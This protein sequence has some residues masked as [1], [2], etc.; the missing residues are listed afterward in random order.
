M[1]LLKREI[2]PI[3]P[4]AWSEI[5]QEARRVLNVK[6]AGRRIVDIDGP[7]GWELGAVNTGL[8]DLFDAHADSGVA[9]GLRKVQPLVEL[10]VPFE[11]N[12]LEL[13]SI[14]RGSETP[15]LDPVAQAAEKIALAEDN[16]IFNGYPEAGI[17]GILQAS[18]HAD[19]PFGKSPEEHMSAVVKARQ[20]L[21]EAGVG[22]PFALLLGPR[23][24]GGLL[25]AL[26]DGDSVFT[27]VHDVVGGPIY[28]A[29]ALD[30]GVLVSTRGGDLTLTIGQDFSIGYVTAD[31]DKVELYL[32]SSFT[33]RA[34]GP[35]AA[36][37]M[38]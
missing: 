2:A 23:P 7:H 9:A 36:V 3:T 21:E 22:G 13:D 1:N 27:R 19:A 29:A 18:P 8:L 34:V 17:Q 37:R 11:L 12:L 6:L 24:Y 16:A 38:P 31:R 35:E 26:E 28:Q 20:S 32:A 4:E 15:D 25:Q 14:S 30:G 5:D 33:F 10:R